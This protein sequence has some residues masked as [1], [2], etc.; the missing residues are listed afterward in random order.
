MKEFVTILMNVT[1]TFLCIYSIIKFYFITKRWRRER[2]EYKQ[3]Y[4]NAERLSE[5]IKK[6]VSDMK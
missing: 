4:N 1:S 6:Q 5:K 3:L 2:K